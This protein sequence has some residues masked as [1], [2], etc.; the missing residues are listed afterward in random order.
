MTDGAT[1]RTTTRLLPRF[2]T[3]SYREVW[4]RVRAIATALHNDSAAPVNPGDFVATIGFA[5]PDYFSVDLACAYLGLVSV[6]LQ[7]NAP[8]SQLRP[9]IAETEP[10][11][12]AVGAQY[13]DLAVES[14]IG[15][16]SLRHLV[17][18]DFDPAVDDQRENLERAQDRVRDAGLPVTV[19]TL[20]DVIERGRSLP[21]EPAYTGGTDERLA[22]IMYTSG[23]TG[24]P[25]GAMITE[26]TL[27]RLWTTNFA[28]P[29]GEAVLNVNFMP[30]N[31]VG[32]RL[33]IMTAFLAGGT[34]FFVPESD[35]STLF[36]DWTLVRPTDMPLVP[37]VVDML[38]QRYRSVIDGLVVE[39][40]RRR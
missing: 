13:L 16:T 30:L 8:V 12:L 11:V 40:L 28:E 14:A 2:E 4:D 25:K 7:H 19:H 3:M 31:H 34:S 39:G 10:K 33:P 24:A 23:S 9:I 26:R 17:V 32:G 20:T 1:G 15:N 6:P 18:F 35:L 37:R 21:P 36:E 22:I 29:T 5:S 38:F 27:G